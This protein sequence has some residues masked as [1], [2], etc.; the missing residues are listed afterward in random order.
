M[1]ISNLRSFYL[2]HI[3]IGI[4]GVSQKASLC[5]W[6]LD[7]HVLPSS[8]IICLEAAAEGPPCLCCITPPLYS[9]KDY[10]AYLPNTHISSMPS[11]DTQDKGS[12]PLTSYVGWS[13]SPLI[14]PY[15]LTTYSYT[16][17][18]IVQ[19]H[20]APTDQRGCMHDSPLC[21]MVLH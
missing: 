17:L 19:T 20:H 4:T 1:R 9:N 3:T 18:S 14:S 12:A 8:L 15:I 2:W 7:P 11:L 16:D 13:L 21:L 6:Y 5:K 10:I